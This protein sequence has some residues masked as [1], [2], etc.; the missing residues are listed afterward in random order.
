MRELESFSDEDFRRTILRAIRLI[1]VLTAVALP[2][3]WWRLG[4]WR[5]AV[6]LLVG[7][8]ISASGLWEWLR[9][10]TALMRRMDASGQAPGKGRGMALLLTGF[11]LRLGLVVVVLYVSLKFLEGSVVALA[12]GLG[13]GV[14]SLT[15][16]GL[17]LVKAWTM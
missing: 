12:V 3:V 10:M 6:M 4:G 9:L 16:E 1:L 8:A 11:F 14:V 2:L 13:L 17:R 5:S 7:A 15:I